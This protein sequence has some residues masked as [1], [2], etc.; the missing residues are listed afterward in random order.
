[1]V[2]AFAGASFVSNVFSHTEPVSVSVH[3]NFALSAH[4]EPDELNLWIEKLIQLESE[5]REDIKILDVNGW[6]SYSC[7]QYQMPTF[8]SYGAKYGFF[9]DGE[10]IS[11]LIYDC[12]LQKRLTRAILESE[13][14]GWKLWYTSVKKRGLGLPPVVPEELALK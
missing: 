12:D 4:Q 7:L 3:E 6:Y 10:D 2:G 13:P 8:E 14:E 9:E 11:D 5:G 1:M